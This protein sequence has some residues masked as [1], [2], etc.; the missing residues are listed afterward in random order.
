MR[1]SSTAPAC[2]RRRSSPIPSATRCL[3]FALGLVLGLGLAFLTEFLDDKIKTA[4]DV[5]RYANGLTVL[6][7]IPTISKEKQG[8]PTRRPRRAQLRRRR[9]LPQ[10]AHQPPAHLPAQADPDA[11]HHERDGGRGQDHHGGEPRRH[12][13]RAAGCAWSSSTSTFAG[14]P[15]RPCSVATTTSV[16]CRCSS[17]RPPWPRRCT[18]CR[19]QPG[20]PPLRFLPAGPIPPNPSE[21]MGTAPHGRGHQ[22]SAGDRRLRDHR[23]AADRAGHRRGRAL[24]PGRCG[25]AGRRRRGRRVA[26]TSSSPPTSSQQADAPMIGAVMNGAGRH[27]Q[28]RLLRAVRIRLQPLLDEEKQKKYKGARPEQER[29]PRIQPE[30]ADHTTSRTLPANGTGT[31]SGNGTN[32]GTG[33]DVESMPETLESG[34]GRRARGRRLPDRAAGSGED[35]RPPTGR[36]A[37][38]SDRT[39]QV[40]SWFRLRRFGRTADSLPDSTRRQREGRLACRSPGRRQDSGSRRSRSGHRPTPSGR[41]SSTVAAHHGFGVEARREADRSTSSPRACCWCCCHRS[42]W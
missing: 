23:L 3:G 4:E 40:N 18:R 16:S 41:R 29:R 24:E 33:A 10:P 32:S 5:A 2:R 20:V 35:P 22:Q 42:S 21:I 7:E 12:A 26:V 6:A 30:E 1:P 15:S 19:S 17:A 34:S 36:G 39:E 14:P 8:S 9:G 37:S 28:L 25:D 13:R 31:G 11:A 38:R 27:A